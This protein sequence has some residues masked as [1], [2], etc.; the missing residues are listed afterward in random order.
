[1]DK[2]IAAEW[3]AWAKIPKE[4]HHMMN[5]IESG[6]VAQRYNIKE[7]QPDWFRVNGNESGDWFAVAIFLLV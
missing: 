7:K 4:V 1:M 5:G 6:R 3:Q 2:R